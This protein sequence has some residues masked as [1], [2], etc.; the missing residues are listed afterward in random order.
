MVVGIFSLHHIVLFSL[1][2]HIILR[3]FLAGWVSFCLMVCCTAGCCLITHMSVM[4]DSV[5]IVIPSVV[6][7]VAGW[8]SV[9]AMMPES[10]TTRKASVIIPMLM[11]FCCIIR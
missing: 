1:G 6:L 11:C 8:L 3:L 10:V 4:I 5:P 2:R 9:F 7:R